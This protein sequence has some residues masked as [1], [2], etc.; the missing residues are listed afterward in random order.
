LG[1]RRIQT[2]AERS[3]VFFPAEGYMEEKTFLYIVTSLVTVKMSAK[4]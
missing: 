2:I 4:E 1:S 3:W